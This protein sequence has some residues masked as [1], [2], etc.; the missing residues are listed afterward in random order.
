MVYATKL[1]YIQVPRDASARGGFMVKFN[2]KITFGEHGR[3]RRAGL[4][5]RLS[6][7]IGSRS[8]AIDARRCSTIIEQRFTCQACGTKVILVVTPRSA[9][10]GRCARYQ[11]QANEMVAHQ[12]KRL[13]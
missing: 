12:R 3:A 13:S 6:T 9:S 5:L 2:R 4:L 11:R 10:A 1:S 8:G 7:T